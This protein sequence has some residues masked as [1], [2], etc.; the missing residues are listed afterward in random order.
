ML[1]T[2]VGPG[3]AAVKDS[4][5]EPFKGYLASSADL[6]QVGESRLKD[7]SPRKRADMLEYA[8]ERYYQ[9]TALMGAPESCQRMVGRWPPPGWTR[10]R[11]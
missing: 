7:L 10:S 3:R 8:F 6:W 5:R 11:A 1:H 9:R 4:V 2:F